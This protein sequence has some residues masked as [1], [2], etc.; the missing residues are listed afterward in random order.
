MDMEITFPGGLRVDAEA[1]GKLVKTDQPPM[2]GGEGSAPEPFLLFLASIGTCAGIY[3]LSFCRAR[4]ISTD[5]I[6]LIQK[7]ERNP[8]TGLIDSIE[9]EIR[10]PAEFPEKYHKAIV[11]TANMC[12]VKKHLENP[13]K[14]KTYAKVG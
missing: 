1:L 8:M 13:P 6:K 5:D 2:A 14:I 9:L 12:A 10:L 4:G 3:V 11:K 7:M